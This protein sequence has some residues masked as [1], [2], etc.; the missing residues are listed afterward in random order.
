MSKFKF[1]VTNN[2]NASSRIFDCYNDAETYAITAVEKYDNKEVEY[3]S[4]ISRIEEVLIVRSK[5]H[6]NGTKELII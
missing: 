2:C 6:N 4:F 1:K 5:L 3:R